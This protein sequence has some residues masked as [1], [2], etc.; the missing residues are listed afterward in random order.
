MT[1]DSTALD[2]SEQ[3]VGKDKVI[4]GNGASLPIT[5]TGTSK[6][7]SNLK[8]LDVLLVP[9]LTKNLLSISK[10]TS[11]FPL[12]V[13]FTDSSFII[14]NKIT[15]KVVA[16]GR[17]DGGL[18][19]LERSNDAFIFVLNKSILT[20]SYDL[21]HARL[22]H[23]NHSIISLLNKKGQLSLTSILPTPAICATC[24]FTKSHKLPFSTNDTWS[25]SI[26]GLVHYDIWGPA[27]VKSKMG[28]TYYVIFVNDHSRFT[29]L[30]PMKFKYD[31]LIFFFNF[32]PLWKINILAR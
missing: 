16:T 4:V 21:W 18:Y 25:T 28:F 9:H 30:Y 3:Y 19:V 26:L 12:Q 14:Q 15:R 6:P 29:W 11:D 31:L 32:S 24:Q 17:R 22:G 20:A 27:P 7:S 10:L 8:L 13:I 1:P 5:H 23:V 2:T